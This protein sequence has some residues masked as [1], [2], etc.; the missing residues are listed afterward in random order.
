MFNIN[1]SQTVIAAI[2]ALLLTAVSIGA[3]AG[4]V[5]AIETSPVAVAGSAAPVANHAN[6]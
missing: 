4:P 1:L 5:G 2:G 3:A 6:V